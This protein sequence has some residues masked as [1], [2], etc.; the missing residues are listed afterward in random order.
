MEPSRKIPLLSLFLIVSFLISCKAFSLSEITHYPYT[1]V[2]IFGDSLSDAGNPNSS[3]PQLD[4]VG[5]NSWVHVKG[6]IGAPITNVDAQSKKHLLWVNYFVNE[7]F[8]GQEVFPASQMKALKLDPLKD[9]ITYAY[10]SAE[11]GLHYINDALY[12]TPLYHPYG[13]KYCN[14]HGPGKIDSDNA[15]VPSVLRQIQFYLTD[16][17]QHPNPQ[18]LF[19]IWVGGNDIFNNAGKLITASMHAK[20][21]L[22]DTIK[23]LLSHLSPSSTWDLYSSDN[24]S[25]PISNILRAKDMLVN[26]GVSPRQIYVIDLP[27]LSKTPAA[28]NFTKG[29]SLLLGALS[30]LTNSYNTN[31]RIALAY[32]LLN[33]ANLPASHIYSANHLFKEIV[34]DPQKFG[35]DNVKESC[36]DRQAVPYCQGYVFFDDKHPTSASGRIMAKRFADY[37]RMQVA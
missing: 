14:D 18:S 7:Y 4:D 24:Y 28:V 5:N 8:T 2:I 19:I 23:Q 29:N 6:K 10:A 16:V 37:L 1:N 3:L 22:A 31:L 11:S 9:N 33:G 32:N 17:N 27:D 15:C 34:N 26:A 20:A 25:R 13:D 21:T 12:P 36:V 35:F 30:M